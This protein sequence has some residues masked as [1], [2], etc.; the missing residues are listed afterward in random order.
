MVFAERTLMLS[1]SEAQK[2]PPGDIV[3]RTMTADT[4]VV[5]LFRGMPGAYLTIRHGFDGNH[6]KMTNGRPHD[7]HIDEGRQNYTI[8]VTLGTA[9]RDYNLTMIW[10]QSC[11]KM[12]CPKGKATKIQAVDEGSTAWS[13]LCL[14]EKCSN[15]DVAHCCVSSA[16]CSTFGFPC[17]AHNVLRHDAAKVFCSGIECREDE[18]EICCEQRATC[19]DF[20]SGCGDDMLIQDNLDEIECELAKCTKKDRDVCCQ[21]KAK[22]SAYTGPCPADQIVRMDADDAFCGG[23]ECTDEDM[24]GCCEPQASCR[25]FALAFTCPDGQAVVQPP[26]KTKCKG[27][28]C[29]A[30]DVDTC[31]EARGK[32]SDLH[33]PG[34]TELKPG[35]EEAL[36][37]FS[38]C[39]VHHDK[40]TCCMI[41]A[42]C[43]EA[44]TNA[45]CPDGHW[46][47]NHNESLCAGEECTDEEKAA[48]C[49]PMASCAKFVYDCPV[50]HMLKLSHSHAHCRSEECDEQDSKTCCSPIPGITGASLSHA[51]DDILSADV[52]EYLEENPDSMRK[53]SGSWIIGLED[54][55]CHSTCQSAGLVCTEAGLFAKNADVDGEEEVLDM[56]Q[57]SNHLDLQTYDGDCPE[58][59]GTNWAIPLV[60]VDG[61]TRS[62]EGRPLDSFD[63]SAA[64]D[65]EE[66]MMKHRLCYCHEVINGIS[67]LVDDDDVRGE[68]SSASKEGTTSEPYD[69]AAGFGHWETGWSDSKKEW[70]CENKGIGC[71][72]ET[73]ELFDIFSSLITAHDCWHVDFEDWSSTQT[74]WCSREHGVH[75][76][77]KTGARYIG[78]SLVMK[79]GKSVGNFKVETLGECARKC[80]ETP[81]CNSFSFSPD[82]G[83][84]R[85]GCNLKGRV[86]T[87]DEA[88]SDN[89][90]KG[91]YKTYYK[92]RLL[93]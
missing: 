34:H 48:C 3:C 17:P 83:L 19:S 85:E 38:H 79:E 8:R 80:D 20:H 24:A 64:P 10:S 72:G 28:E 51:S 7:L 22:C 84:T 81:E 65:E 63:C 32:C 9:Q 82:A 54:R 59:D 61:C 67:E 91:D 42:S 37:K 57:S 11:D 75:V 21:D 14:E 13:R 92:A 89:P 78:R 76:T 29:S 16:S 39:S 73:K 18:A 46:L 55:D 41:R 58:D 44:M 36:C 35:S 31:C 5:P 23:L 12:Q 77:T 45:D 87:A 69:C 26:T 6:E 60:W 86:V 50:G 52:V 49:K 56:M 53:V 43:T 66:K 68:V 47:P 4:K 88:E 30:A 25:D 2:I 40:S 1:W 15:L 33:C 74:L 71:E 62:T 93:P 27:G 70:C 90:K